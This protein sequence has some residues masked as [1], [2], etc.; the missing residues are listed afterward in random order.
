VRSV[1][2]DLRDAKHGHIR[3]LARWLRIEGAD[4]LMAETLIEE[5][6]TEIWRETVKAKQK[7]SKR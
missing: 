4:F 1:V 5:V 6:A 7:G 2:V 3:R